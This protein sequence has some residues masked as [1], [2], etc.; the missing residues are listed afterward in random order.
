MLRSQRKT[1][2]SY[3]STRDH[4]NSAGKKSFPVQKVEISK[5]RRHFIF[6]A[7]IRWNFMLNGTLLIQKPTRLVNWSLFLTIKVIFSRTF[8]EFLRKIELFLLFKMADFS[9]LCPQI[10]AS[11]ISC[12]RRFHHFS[13]FHELKKDF[14]VIERAFLKSSGAFPLR[15]Q[16]N[17]ENF[18]FRL[19]KIVS[20]LERSLNS[21]ENAFHVG[22]KRER[23]NS[24]NFTSCQNSERQARRVIWL[25]ARAVEI[26]TIFS[27]PK[28][29]RSSW[30]EQTNYLD[31]DVRNRLW[32]HHFESLR[33]K[34]FSDDDCDFIWIIFYFES[35]CKAL[36]AITMTNERVGVAGINI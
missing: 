8:L 26:S 32:R 7:N 16:S 20:H 2:L 21:P 5:F 29:V 3:Q 35:E 12:A 36:Q 19:V 27:K 18:H 31:Y 23:R 13:N 9:F 28:H 34:I 6:F 17:K 4:Q 11:F 10:A 1:K 14:L 24:R 33:V 22:T 15:Y 30:C 25:R